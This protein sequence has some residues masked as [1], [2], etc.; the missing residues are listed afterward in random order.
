VPFLRGA[1]RAEVRED[2]GSGAGD[3]AAVVCVIVNS[4]TLTAETHRA[5]RKSK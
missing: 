2:E 3:F 4:K 5:Q 1:C